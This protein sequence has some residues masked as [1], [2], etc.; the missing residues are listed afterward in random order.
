MQEIDPKEATIIHKNNRKRVLRAIEIYLIN[1]EAKSSINAKQEHKAIY[2]V[3]FLF[4]D[5]SRD[6]LY[7]RINQRV[8]KMIEDGLI[9]EAKRFY[10]YK[11]FKSIQTAIGYKELF[12]YFEGKISL[13][14]AIELIKKNTRNYAKRQMTYFNNKMN[15]KW[16]KRQEL[17]KM[18]EYIDKQ[19]GH[20]FN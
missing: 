12:L 2:D 17:E 9:D 6:V 19:V 18:I 4:K 7:E 16:F 14:D 10:P 3:T 15:V 5:I 1:G 11:D 13:D 8:D 20:G